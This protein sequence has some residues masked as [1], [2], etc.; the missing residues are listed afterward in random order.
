MLFVGGL[1]DSLYERS[2]TP[3]LFHESHP[4]CSK[5]TLNT[6]YF[7]YSIITETTV[8]SLWEN[9]PL[10]W[11]SMKSEVFLEWTDS[12]LLYV[13]G[14]IMKESG[15]LSCF[16]VLSK[17]CLLWRKPRF[18]LNWNGEGY[19]FLWTHHI[20]DYY[21]CSVVELT[22]VGR[23]PGPCL[24]HCLEGMILIEGLDLGIFNLHFVLLM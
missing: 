7:R 17:L 8:C 1:H 10:H 12:A 9:I 21:I 2:H 4:C 19:L 16:M 6:S 23:L 18:S 22:P 15:S 11:E 13:P 5:I 20:G 3:D 14:I 24:V